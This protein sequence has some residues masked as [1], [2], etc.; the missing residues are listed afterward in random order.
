MKNTEAEDERKRVKNEEEQS[1][2]EQK[3]QEDRALEKKE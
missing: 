3:K 2:D 1:M